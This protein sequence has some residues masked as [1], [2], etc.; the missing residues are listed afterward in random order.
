MPAVGKMFSR[1][2]RE[3]FLF[4]FPRRGK[5]EWAFGQSGTSPVTSDCVVLGK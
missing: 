3:C 1:T 4:L 5:R 2:L